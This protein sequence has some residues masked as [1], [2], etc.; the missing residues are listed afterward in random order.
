[1]KES[2]PIDQILC[3]KCSRE[4]ASLF[5]NSTYDDSCGLVR[6]LIRDE[7]IDL[8][9][10]IRARYLQGG[11][12]STQSVILGTAGIGKSVFRLYL[13]WKWMRNDPDIAQFDFKEVLINVHEIYFIVQK[14]GTTRRIPAASAGAYTS[15]A[16]LDPCLLVEGQVLPAKMLVVMASPSSI[17]GHVGKPSLTQLRKL[18]YLYVMKSWSVEELR[19][20][21]P[22]V[23]AKQLERFSAFDGTSAYCVP[24]WFFYTDAEVEGQLDSCWSNHSR[25]AIH[26]FFLKEAYD[27]NQNSCLPFRLCSIVENGPN[28]WKVAGFISGYVGEKVYK[29][30]GIGLHLDRAGFL[31]LLDHP[32]GGGL[33]GSWYERWA[34]ECI[35]RQETILVSNK[36]LGLP[37][38][39]KNQEFAFEKLEVFDVADPRRGQ[40]RVEVKLET[41]T[42][43][44]PRSK[45]FPSID[46]YGKTSGGDLV[47]LKFTKA[48]SHSAALWKDILA[49]VRKAN[50]QKDI[51]RMVLIYCCPLVDE[52][53]TPS[54]PALDGRNVIVCKGTM[55]SD[56]LL[57]LRQK[58][59]REVVP[60]L[61]VLRKSQ[62]RR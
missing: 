25:E 16:L 22:D 60:E 7:Y 48:M 23:K 57:Q 29:W 18:S 30:A 5:S 8:W 45:V 55:K 2:Q 59:E 43:Y 4:I 53:R 33:I 51:K 47:F 17:V 27:L 56:F 54:C 3:V 38:P 19:K 14:D 13:I 20:I 21:K 28:R 11:M 61:D 52:F 6:I 26:D 39:G 34:L 36:Q 1:M 58:R 35:E 15:L 40:P 37:R 49:I 10:Q 44:K 41:G 12:T 32:L 9:Q 50:T 31:N 42:L 62:R 24:R 46:A